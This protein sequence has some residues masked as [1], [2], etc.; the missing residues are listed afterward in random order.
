MKIFGLLHI[1]KNELSSTNLSTKNFEEQLSVYINNAIV[2][3]KSLSL[4]SIEFGLLTNNKQLVEELASKTDDE[5]SLEIIEIPFITKVPS[6]VR[7]YSAHYKI[8]AFRYVASLKDSYYAICDLDMVCID[9]LPI[10]LQNIIKERI[11]LCYDISDQVIPAYGHDLI[12]RDLSIIGGLASEGRWSGGEFISGPPEFFIKL[13]SEID[14][15]Y[16]KY[17]TAIPSLHHIGDESITS[18]ALERMKRQ[19]V[20]IADAGN[21]FIVGRYWNTS[22]LHP[23][24]P[25]AYYKNCFLLHLPSDKKLISS[26]ARLKAEALIDFLPI[27]EKK[28]GSLSS[29]LE[30]GLKFIVKFIIRTFKKVLHCTAIRDR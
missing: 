5:F 6:G 3:S 28:L 8:D 15:V 29:K 17:V 22:V 13:V 27:Y 16:D 12:I 7:F 11:P 20:Y 10:C 1:A 24:K 30:K 19:G 14:A 21:L 25:F 18:S 9:G 2:L 23:Q 4:Q 26:M